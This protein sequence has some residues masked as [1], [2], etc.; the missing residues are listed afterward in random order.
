MMTRILPL[1]IGAS[2]ARSRFLDRRHARLAWLC[3]GIDRPALPGRRPPNRARPPPTAGTSGA[4]PVR[5]SRQGQPAG[6]SAAAA[7][8]GMAAQPNQ[9]TGQRNHRRPEEAPSSAGWSSSPPTKGPTGGFGADGPGG[10][11]HAG[12]TALAGLAFMSAGNLPGRGKYGKQVQKCLDYVLSCEQ[13]SGLICAD[14]NQGPM[15]G[16]GFATLFLGEVYGMTG[17]E[18]VKEKLQKAVQ[19]IEKTQNS[20][21]GWRYQPAPY[22][23]DI[24][25]TICQV[26]A[27]R[28]ARDAGIKVEKEV[29]DKSIKYV[30]T[31]QNRSDGGFGYQPHDARRRQR[32][33]PHRRRRGQPLLRRRLRR[34]RSSPRGL[35]YLK[36]FIPG[37]QLRA[38]DGR[39]VLLRQLLRRPGHVPRRRRLL[40]QLLP[41]HPRPAHPAART[42]RPAPGRARPATTTPPPWR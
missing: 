40:G 2:P 6:P 35:K 4:A 28:A 25:V 30:K 16:H 10:P 38:V 15:Y 37:K 21:G 27:L 13:Q 12:I 22:D 3:A 42:S 34:R 41:R 7:A 39:D 14:V 29:I 19:L 9:V 32:L 1:R 31:C 26:M 17:N 36:Q 23:A 18:E 5:A 20:E 8:A 11:K 33:R 24:S